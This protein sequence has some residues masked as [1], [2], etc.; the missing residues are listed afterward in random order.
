MRKSRS[1]GKGIVFREGM[2]RV[3]PGWQDRAGLVTANIQIVTNLE[4]MNRSD[5]PGL[6]SKS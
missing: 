6:P 2:V 5:S 4:T 3:T 1:E